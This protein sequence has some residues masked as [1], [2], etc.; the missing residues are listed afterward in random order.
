[1]KAYGG[2]YSSICNSLYFCMEWLASSLGHITPE[3]R[4]LCTFWMGDWTGPRGGRDL[5]EKCF[6]LVVT[7]PTEL[8]LL[9]LF[10]WSNNTLVGDSLLRARV[11]GRSVP[12][13]C[14]LLP[15]GL[16]QQTYLY[17]STRRHIAEVCDTARNVC[18]VQRIDRRFTRRLQQ[19]MTD[20]TRPPD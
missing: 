5:I 14:H 18:C 9:P 6:L 11:V 12:L 17:Q 10:N 16:R 1:V 8:P 13:C 3:S 19:L 20:C 15:W 4:A 2:E 7:M